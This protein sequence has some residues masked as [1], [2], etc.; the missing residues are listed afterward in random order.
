M[1]FMA[2]EKEPGHRCNNARE[3]HAKRQTQAT[4]FREYTLSAERDFR[5]KLAPL[6]VDGELV[7]TFLDG[8]PSALPLA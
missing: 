2:L 7:D 6:Y 4:C 1:G 3:N 8:N 5:K